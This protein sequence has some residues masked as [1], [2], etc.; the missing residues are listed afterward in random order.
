MENLNLKFNA[1]F[2][3]ITSDGFLRTDNV[4]GDIPFYIEHYDAAQEIEITAGIKHLK[5]KL[6]ASNG[7]KILELNLFN[8]VCDILEEKGS[9][10]RL[11]QVEKNKKK[12]KFLKALQS[13]LNIHEVLMPKIAEMIQAHEPSV[14]FLTGIGLVFPFIRSHVILNNLQTI[15]TNAPTIAFYPGNYDGNSLNLFSLLKDDNYYRAFPLIPKK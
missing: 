2:E 12:D 14:Y 8:I 5:N 10:E 6:E 4:G 15:A 7:I 11:F 13:T 3:K 1:V 9:M